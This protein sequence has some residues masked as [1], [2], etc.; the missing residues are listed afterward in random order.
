MASTNLTISIELFSVLLIL[1][2][3]HYQHQIQGE[4]F[5]LALDSTIFKGNGDYYVQCLKLP[6]LYFVYEGL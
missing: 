4:F 1:S 6:D 5:Y 3:S 2:N